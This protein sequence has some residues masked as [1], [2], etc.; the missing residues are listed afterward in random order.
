MTGLSWAV[1][2]LTS[3]R[4][5]AWVWRKTTI[6]GDVMKPKVGDHID[7]RSDRFTW[8]DGKERSGCILRIDG[9]IVETTGGIA[10]DMRCAKPPVWNE[11]EQLWVV[12]VG[13]ADR[14]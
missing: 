13:R 14:E 5:R 1:S 11:E 7:F 12:S 8:G 4:P 2:D 6:L 9:D 3:R 10:T